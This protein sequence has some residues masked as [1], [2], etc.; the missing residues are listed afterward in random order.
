MTTL[1]RW[2]LSHKL[3][4]AGFWLILAVVGFASVQSAS[5]ALSLKFSF[6]GKEGYEADT[7]ILRTYGTD[8]TNPPFVPVVT[9][10]AGTTV[11]SPGVRSE[12]T[13]AFGA[14]AARTPGS[15]S[16]SYASTGN[17]AF[18]SKDGRTTFGL[19]Y[20]PVGLGFNGTT[21]AQDNIKSALAGATVA[22]RHFYLSGIDPLASGGG[23]GGGGPSILI[24]ALL[25]GVG[26]LF[27]L[28]FVFRSFMAIVPLLMAV[29]AIPIT[30]L[31]I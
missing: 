24:E 14:I 10:P 3:I 31:L 29:V 8:P 12:L 17:P 16:I 19:V 28:I 9:M 2:V 22:G 5:N 20:A 27:I 30:F 4:V 18:V 25:G 1:T 7:G 21:I 11:R 26:A 6:P 13:R 23:G 15:R